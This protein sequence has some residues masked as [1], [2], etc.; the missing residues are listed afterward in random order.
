ML[1]GSNLK[2]ISAA[3]ETLPIDLSRTASE[4]VDVA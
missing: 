3:K 4:M 2:T 1:H